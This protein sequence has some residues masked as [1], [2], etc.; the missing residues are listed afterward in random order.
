MQIVQSQ[1]RIT[2]ERML[3]LPGI[4]KDLGVIDLKIEFYDAIGIRKQNVTGIKSGKQH[5][6]A[7]QILLACEIFG[8]NANYIFGF[9]DTKFRKTK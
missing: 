6:T 3:S 9:S 4:L 7:G 2:D 5:F 8:I 1:L